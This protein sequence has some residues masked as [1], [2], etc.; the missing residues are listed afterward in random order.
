MTSG[1]SIP[2][3]HPDSGLSPFELAVPAR[4]EECLTRGCG[5]GIGRT[6]PGARRGRGLLRRRETR[7][8][9]C[10]SQDPLGAP[11]TAAAPTRGRQALLQYTASGRSAGAGQRP[12]PG[13]PGEGPPKGLRPPTPLRP[14]PL[15]PRPP[16]W[17]GPGLPGPSPAL[18][19]AP[20]GTTVE[21]PCRAAGCP[22]PGQGR[23]R[24]RGESKLAHSGDTVGTPSLGA[25]QQPPPLSA[26]H[27]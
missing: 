7:E 5:R 20:V 4:S 25:P 19:T 26:L 27:G 17:V 11:G 6:D 8:A 3:P 13:L 10:G 12:Q 23:S 1:P 15:A 22:A 14:S 9:H 16:L 21:G 18:A 2:L 24:C